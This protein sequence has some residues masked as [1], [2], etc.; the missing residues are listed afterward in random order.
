VTS[1]TVQRILFGIFGVFIVILLVRELATGRSGF[2]ERTLRRTTD[3][4]SYWGAVGM[5]LILLLTCALVAVPTGRPYMPAIL[6]G[7]FGALFFQLLVSGKIRDGAGGVATRASNPGLYRSRMAF[8][9]V[10]LA[11]CLIILVLDRFL[12]TAP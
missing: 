8:Y 9:G 10:L 7:I 4:R 2:G 5:N 6:I 11:I 3:P 1:E 12:S